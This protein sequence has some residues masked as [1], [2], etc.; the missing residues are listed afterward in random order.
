[1]S[2]AKDS[3]SKLNQLKELGF[4]LAI[5]DFGTGYSSLSYLRNFPIDTLKIDRSFIMDIGTPDGDAIVRAILGMASALNLRVVAE[6]I[7]TQQQATFLAQHRCDCLQG[8]LFAKPL[9]V[10]DLLAATTV[11]YSPLLKPA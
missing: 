7:E 10:T 1:M 9:D 5:D 4:D 2:D 11:D 8:Y 6:G 3:L